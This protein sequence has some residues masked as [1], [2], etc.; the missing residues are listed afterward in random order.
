MN[1]INEKI[2]GVGL[3]RKAAK[4]SARY[5]LEQSMVRQHGR[6]KAAGILVPT[7]LFRNVVLRPRSVDAT[8][9]FLKSYRAIGLVF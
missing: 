6:G 1:L 9:G 3:T 2:S 8:G 7:G 4:D 5:Q